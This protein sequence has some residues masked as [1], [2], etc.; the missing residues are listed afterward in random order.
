[1]L[2]I[3]IDIGGTFTD[4]VIY[5]PI[6][7]TISTFK[8]PTDPNDPAVSVINGLKQITEDSDI[9]IIHGSTV[10]TNALLERKGA[11]T[12]LIT[13]LGFKDILQIGRQNRQ[14]LY[15]LS[16]STIS[17]I[18]PRHLRYEVEERVEHNGI[19]LKPLDLDALDHT[20]KSICDQ[21]IE[22]IA[23]CLLFSFLHP[24]HE[25]LIASR[26]RELG[27]FV[28][29][30]NE[31]LPE[32]REYER[33]CTTVINAYVSPKLSKYLT[34]FQNAFRN[35]QI[36]VMQSNGGMISIDEAQR[37]G[38]RCILSGPA[39]GIVG[40]IHI[41]RNIQACE[42][43]VL[44]KANLITFDM[45]GTSTDVSLVS[46]SPKMTKEA[47]IGG[48]PIA[49]PIL[50]IH[51]IGAGGGSIA[52]IDLA[53]ALLV[54]PDSAGAYPGPACYGIGNTPTVTD[55][56]LILGRIPPEFFLGGK[57]TL[58]FDRAYETL[59]QLGEQIGLS[60]YQAAL[61]VL[62]VV[63]AHMERAIRVIS[64]E[65][66][67][68]PHDF[69]LVTFGGAGGLHASDLARRV[70]IPKV[71]IP[72]MAST[73]S[74]YGMLAAD[75]IRDYSLTLMLPGDTDLVEL[76]KSFKKLIS[77]GKTE[78]LQAG[79]SQEKIII[80][81]S[82]DMRYSGQ[83]YELNIPFSNSICNDFAEIHFATYGYKLP[84]DDV[85]IVT[86]RARAIG[87]VEKPKSLAYPLGDPDPSP[88]LFT[89]R[90]IHLPHEERTVPFFKGEFLRP[91]NVIM[92]PAVIARQDTTIFLN[93]DDT[94]V[95]DEF[96]NLII[97]VSLD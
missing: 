17:P 86:I 65:K 42:K 25:T 6:D 92:G 33:T 36:Q 9:T 27:Y 73:L 79:F 97:S 37:F 4:F 31:V 50:D 35:A 57:I 69:T 51:S 91:G 81:L 78:L 20:L 74:A 48:L 95:V 12:A 49:L 22:S 45:G 7:N 1:M 46:Q 29:C 38:V 30:S 43:E 55:A 56:N 64:V 8:L 90:L 59:Q 14:N 18:V 67:Y 80:E 93:L 5:N 94:A 63:N 62:E 2:R 15:S 88:A 32:F 19:V 58:D 44:D 11:N 39:G 75:F 21:D 13:T 26:L 40:A 83:S 87:K 41:A 76:Q 47:T 89:N 54:G 34:N 85:E 70:G 71:I 96:L 66:G 16:P 68:D 10:A 53:G 77:R 61:G 3:G 72:P 24:D 84:E 52:K 23:I 28:S 60:A 82:V